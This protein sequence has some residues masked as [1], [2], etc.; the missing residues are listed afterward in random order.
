VLPGG[1]Q[2]ATLRDAIQHQREHDH[3]A[4][5]LLAATVLTNAAEGRDVSHAR[6]DRG[7]AGVE[8]ER[9]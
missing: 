2:L 8:Q 5:R 7:V 1:K 6:A 9:R 3:P 4:V